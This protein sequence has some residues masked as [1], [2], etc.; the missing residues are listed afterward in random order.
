MSAIKQRAIER[1]RLVERI[2]QQRAALS[3]ELAPVV[4]ILNTAD[5]VLDGAERTRRWITENPIV[6]GAGM[7][8]LLIWRPKGAFKLAKN[9]AVGWRALRL[10]RRLLI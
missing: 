1:G 7:L 8:A 2:D 9:G 3:V 6:A 5:Q 10:V 4:G